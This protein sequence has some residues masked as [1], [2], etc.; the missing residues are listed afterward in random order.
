MKKKLETSITQL[1]SKVSST[2]AVLCRGKVIQ[3]N[4]S[5]H[6]LHTLLHTCITIFDLPCRDLG[7]Q[8]LEFT[9]SSIHSTEKSNQDNT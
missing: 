9:L 6:T 2:I 8:F 1:Q 3:D 7:Q 5:L 4:A